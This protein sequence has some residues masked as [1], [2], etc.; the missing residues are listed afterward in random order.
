[1][2]KRKEK[3][4]QVSS[5]SK[6][7]NRGQG[8]EGGGGKEKDE[9][10]DLVYVQS[11]LFFNADHLAFFTYRLMAV[12]VDRMMVAY[13][14]V[15]TILSVLLV[16]E[17]HRRPQWREKRTCKPIFFLSSNSGSAVQDKKLTTSLAI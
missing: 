17:K 2:Q 3:G 5:V 10:G 9:S 16:L 7:R 11:F 1:V 4:D 8:V 14:V 13:D 6:T 15:I 12:K